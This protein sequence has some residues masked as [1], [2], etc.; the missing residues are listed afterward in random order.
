MKLENNRQHFWQWDAGCTLLLEETADRVDFCVSGSEEIYSVL[1]DSGKVTVPDIC[2]CTDGTLDVYCVRLQPDGQ[3]T[4]S[5][6]SFRVVPRGKPSDYVY[7]PEEF[8]SYSGLSSR[9]DGMLTAPEGG[10][11]GQVLTKTV[12]GHIWSNG[13]G[14]G[15]GTTFYPHVSDEGILT[16]E[17]DL[18]LPNPEPVSLMGAVGA[19]GFTPTISV[20]AVEDGFLLTI[21]NRDQTNR[22]LL[23]RGTSDG[24]GSAGATFTPHISADGILSWTNDMDLTNP[25]PICIRGSDGQPGPM[26]PT[27]DTGPQGP[28]GP[29]G[30]PGSDGYT[31]VKGVD[32]FT[33]EEITAMHAD[34][35]TRDGGTMNGSLD[36]GGNG[37][38]GIRAPEESMDAANKEYVDRARLIFRNVRVETAHFIPDATYVDF[39]YKADIALNGVLSSMIPEVMFDEI[40]IGVHRA[41]NSYDGGVTVYSDS[42]PDEAVLIPTIILLRGDEV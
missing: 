13:G 19:D 20:E 42:I 16:W 31:P 2:L 15:A 3:E 6:H 24:A 41:C 1:P 34:F 17:N 8:L 40:N 4:S 11:P 22:V 28:A 23:P 32:Y 27:G 36:M 26:G 7:T 18:G 37:L 14:G 38:R 12:D 9:M 25:A 30:Q 39:P 5:C 35:L 21:V 10:E 33:D 29:A